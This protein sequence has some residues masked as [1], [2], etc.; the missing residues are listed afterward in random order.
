MSYYEVPAQ[1]VDDH[2]AIVEWGRKALEAAGRSRTKRPARARTKAIKA[3]SP[4]P[5][6]RKKR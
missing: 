2:R 6:S 4:A 1:V 3:R 5:S